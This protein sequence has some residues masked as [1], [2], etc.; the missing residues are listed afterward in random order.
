MQ[1]LLHTCT[2]M[3]VIS[4]SMSEVDSYFRNKTF[5]EK[6]RRH[7]IPITVVGPRNIT[8]STTYF[9]LFSV[10]KRKC[11]GHYYLDWRAG[12]DDATS[13]QVGRVAEKYKKNLEF[14]HLLIHN[15]YVTP[16]QSWHGLL[17]VFPESGC[18]NTFCIRTYLWYNEFGQFIGKKCKTKCYCEKQ[19]N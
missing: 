19:F 15:F 4:F 16:K 1:T 14:Y 9:Y 6:R 2:I 5:V 7:F 18:L 17:W 13:L 10:M 8:I 11:R 12:T 3:I